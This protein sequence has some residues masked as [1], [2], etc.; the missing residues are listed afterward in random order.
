MENIFI[1]KKPKLLKGS[2]KIPHVLRSQND[3][4]K[5]INMN[6]IKHYFKAK[7]IKDGDIV[8]CCN[9]EDSIIPNPH[10]Y[11]SDDMENGTGGSGY[12]HDLIFKVSSI[13]D[14]GSDII[15]Y[16]GRR[17]NG[18]FA[19][20]VRPATKKEIEIYKNLKK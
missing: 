11:S 5:A 10:D 17:G 15:F 1:L 19:D 12:E 9:K 7:S 3:L 6:I 8:V 18:V 16:G 13:L 20:R 4:I 2:T 14:Y